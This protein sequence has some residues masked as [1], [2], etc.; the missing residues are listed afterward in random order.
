M[1][2]RRQLLL[3]AAAVLAGATG[4]AKVKLPALPGTTPQPGPAPQAQEDPAD[5][6]P[7][8]VLRVALL[9]DPH[10]QESGHGYNKLQQALAD[11]KPLRPD[12]WLV[13]GDVTNLGLAAEYA[14]FKKLLK[15]TVKDDQLLVTTGNHDLY[16]KT[17]TDEEEMGRFKDAFSRKT[18]WSNKV[19]G[20]VHFVMLAT[21]QWKTAPRLPDWAWL[22][23]EQLRWFE[24]VVAEHPDKYTIVSLHQPLQN[25]IIWSH[26][27]SNTFTGCAQL[28]TLQAIMKKNRQIRLWLSGHTHMGAERENSAA[29]INGVTYIGL[30]S[31]FYQFVPASGAEDKFGGF[32]QDFDASGSRLL[33]IWE[34][35]TVIRARDHANQ[36]WLDPYEI[37]L[38]P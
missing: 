37:V 2:S 33:E 38:K 7:R 10:T 34:D 16:D 4:C 3:G 8:P 19:V 24:Q 17:A 29:A 25:T 13:C 27:E 30:G 32:K 26:G 15:G 36:R 11:Y 28:P 20:N 6:T 1:L 12:L 31:T 18:V 14:A 22:S 21:E 23:D 5:K 9:S 35:R